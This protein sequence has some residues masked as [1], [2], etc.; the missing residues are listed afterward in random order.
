VEV[1]VEK[2]ARLRDVDALLILGNDFPDSL[3]LR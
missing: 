2:A 1:P 3:P